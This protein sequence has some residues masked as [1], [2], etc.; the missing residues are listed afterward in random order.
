MARKQMKEQGAAAISLDA[1]W[2]P[3]LF[4]RSAEEAETLRT[5]LEAEGI[6]TLLGEMGGVAGIPLMVPADM[7]SQATEM[8][9]SK[10]ASSADW[11]EDEGD[12]DDLL[13][14]DD[15]EEDEDEDEDEDDDDF[16]PDDDDDAVEEEEFDSAAESE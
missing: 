4:A 2:M 13:D 9:A 3:V 10:D 16:L 11:D 7:E 14:D 8:I 1:D 6:A 12:D 5:M 15:D